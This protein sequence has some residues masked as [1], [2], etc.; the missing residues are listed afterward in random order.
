MEKNTLVCVNIFTLALTDKKQNPNQIPA[1]SLTCRGHQ[2]GAAPTHSQCL[3]WCNQ[4]RTGT[5]EPQAS[6]LHPEGT[7]VVF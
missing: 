4:F 1:G 5:P 3:Q 2:C 7:L 6:S